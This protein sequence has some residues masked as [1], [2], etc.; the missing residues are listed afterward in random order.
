MH[1]RDMDMSSD[2]CIYSPRR[3][4][5]HVLCTLLGSIDFDASTTMTF[6]NCTQLVLHDPHKRHHPDYKYREPLASRFFIFISTPIL[7]LLSL[8]LGAE[9]SYSKKKISLNCR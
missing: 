5:V 7:F 2:T 1:P 6:F 3:I 4:K 9:V 8:F